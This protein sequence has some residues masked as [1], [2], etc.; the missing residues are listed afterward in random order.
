MTYPRYLKRAPMPETSPA[1]VPLYE[2][3][4]DNCTYLGQMPADPSERYGVEVL[5]LYYCPQGV[6][7]TVIARY[8]SEGDYISGLVFAPFVPYIAEA[9]RRAEERGL[10]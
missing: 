9:K 3:D 2:H 4:C 10:L 5:D 6:L 1:S 8:G 7:P